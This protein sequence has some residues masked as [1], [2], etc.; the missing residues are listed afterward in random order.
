VF[1]EHSNSLF[2]YI[3]LN[4]VD[5]PGIMD[6]KYLAVEFCVFH[7]AISYIIWALTHK[8][9]HRALLARKGQFLDEVY[10]IAEALLADKSD[11]LV[12][13]ANGWVLRE[14]GKTNPDRLESFLLAHYSNVPRTTLRYA[15][16]K[17]PPEK[18]KAIL[19]ARV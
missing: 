16:E 1:Q 9:S 6:P 7:N 19:H 4:M 14:A 3:D 8:V 11:D 18:R 5:V 12:Q 2:R 13:K 17:F 10:S 15:I